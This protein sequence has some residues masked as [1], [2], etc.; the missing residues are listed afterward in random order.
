[1]INLLREMVAV[2][3]ENAGAGRGG[4]SAT[5][6]NN[7]RMSTV[8][9][10]TGIKANVVESESGSGGMGRG[11]Q[12]QGQGGVRGGRGMF[13]HVSF[14]IYSQQTDTCA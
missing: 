4:A 10:I 3:R 6:P 7:H 13:L 9:F 1:M 2:V 14:C 12:G 5:T 11:G 8:I